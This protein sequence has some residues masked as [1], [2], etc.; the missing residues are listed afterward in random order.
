MTTGM[1]HGAAPHEAHQ[2]WGL[3]PTVRTANPRD[4]RVASIAERWLE[5][6]S[7]QDPGSAVH[8]DGAGYVDAARVALTYATF[9][10]DEAEQTIAPAP[11]PLTPRLFRDAMGCLATGVCVVTTVAGDDDVAMTANSV[12]S[13]SLEPPLVLVCIARTARF[14]DLVLEAGRWGLS[15]L[16]ATAHELS[17]QFARPGRSQQGQL[18]HARFHRGVF[19]GV[20]LLDSSVVQVECRTEQVHCAGDHSIIVGRVVSVARNGEGDHPLLFHRG[21]YRWLLS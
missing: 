18:Q 2:P 8:D 7:T 9:S 5:A 4:P 21:S 11:A 14:H 12:T 1:P 15:I 20:A 19:T 10:L 3:A 6:Q 16:D 13:V 17:S